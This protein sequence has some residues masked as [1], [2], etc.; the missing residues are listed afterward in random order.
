MIPTPKQEE[1]S[2]LAADVLRRFH[3]VYLAMEERTGKTL[4]AIRTAEKTGKVNV[5]VLTKKAAIDGWLETLAKYRPEGKYFVTNYQQAH[6]LP[7][8]AYDLIILDE[9]HNFISGFPARSATNKLISKLAKG[10]DLIYLSATPYAQGPAL[11]FHQFILSS[12]TPFGAYKTG[13]AFHAHFG[14]P[15]V[16]WIGGVPRETYKKVESD[17]VLAMCDHLFI[18]GTRE[19]MGYK[20]EPTDVIHWIELNDV[21]KQAY[22]IMLKDRVITINEVELDLT[23]LPRLRATLHMLEGGVMKNGKDYHVLGNT[24]KIDYIKK[25]WGDT[26]D[27]VIMYYFKAEAVKL[28]DHFENAL[29]L[30]ATRFAEGVDLHM[31]RHL[32]IYSQDWSTARHSQRRARQANKN[33]EDEI[34]V[35]FLLCK[36]AISD[37]V[38]NTV[39]VNK[40]NFIDSCFERIML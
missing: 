28:Q 13:Y 32:V 6:K 10:L 21:T 1:K 38:Y 31:Y 25:T 20:H 40:T 9:A 37:Q 4:T 3:L 26:K 18:G 7:K 35:H 34:L 5:L 27:L 39:S 14:I 16:V 11:L 29:L 36:G 33:R 30:Q 12:W 8:E 23:K 19:E 2:E 15:D 24:E 22:N 17:D